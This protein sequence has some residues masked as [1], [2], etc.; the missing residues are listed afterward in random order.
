MNIIIGSGIIIFVCGLFLGANVLCD[1]DGNVKL[2]DFG[3][4]KQ[5][6]AI[7]R[8]TTSTGTWHYMSPEIITARDYSNRT[9]IW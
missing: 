6:E 5:L 2:S 1:C 7:S 3:A 9:D 8:M 4:A